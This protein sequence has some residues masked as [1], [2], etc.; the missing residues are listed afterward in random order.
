MIFC[1]QC[2]LQLALGTVTC[3]RCGTTVEE[4]K[5]GIDALHANDNTVAGQSIP[6][7]SQ[8]GPSMP[9]TP[10]QPLVLRPGTTTN[11][12]NPQDATSM[13]EAPTYGTNMPPGQ[14]MAMQYPAGGHFPTPASYPN[15][16]MPGGTYA[17]GGMSI[18]G[19]TNQ[20][21]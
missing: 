10:P 9:G 17:P 11:S 20:M 3:P 8:A 6:H 18:P 19:I 1:G 4:A 14:P 12:Y 2:G 13:M 5:A 21:G 15:Y 7:L 16:S